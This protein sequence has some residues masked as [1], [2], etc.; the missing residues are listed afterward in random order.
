MLS[1][2]E[3]QRI[4][5]EERL[6][7]SLKPQMP[8]K[9]W[10]VVWR[11]SNSPIVLAVMVTSLL[12]ILTETFKRSEACRVGLSQANRYY[13]ELHSE[14]IYQLQQKL[15]AIESSAL[16]SKDAAEADKIFQTPVPASHAEFKDTPFLD[17]VD[18]E[19]RLGQAF[20]VHLVSFPISIQSDSLFVLRAIAA[21]PRANASSLS[22]PGLLA[23]AMT[24][25]SSKDFEE[26][27]KN[28][29]HA[30]ER[31]GEV[32]FFSTMFGSPITLSYDCGVW[33]TIRAELSGKV[34]PFSLGILPRDATSFN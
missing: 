10:D 15:A 26:A 17:L 29:L 18:A 8:T 24:G 9:W 34:S 3:R 4:A 19:M 22:Q 28:I 32:N 1:R 13:R 31:E 5:D 11:I 27:I 20:G 2:R 12:G 6:R 23:R 21:S 30:Q 33:S 7:N 14:I 25:S 16:G